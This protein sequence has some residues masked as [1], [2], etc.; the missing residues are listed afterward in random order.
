MTNSFLAGLRDLSTIR[1]NS[2]V[3][4]N[5]AKTIKS[6]MAAVENYDA[7]RKSII[8]TRCEMVDGKPKVDKEKNEYMFAS[9]EIKADTEKQ[10]ADLSKE[11]VEIEIYPIKLDDLSNTE[12]SAQVLLSL[13]EFI[14]E[15]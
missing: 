14:T 10:I 12:L 9:E 15:N 2:K 13:K 1:T 5:T 8:E 4:Y 6:T 11:E 7:A 3:A